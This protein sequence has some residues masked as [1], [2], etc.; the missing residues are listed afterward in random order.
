MGKRM[1]IFIV[2]ASEAFL[3]ISAGRDWALLGSLWLVG[4]H[5]RF[6]ILEWSTAVWMR[7]AG[8]FLAIVVEAIAIGSWTVQGVSRMARRDRESAGI[9][10]L[11]IRLVRSGMEVG[12]CSATSESGRSWPMRV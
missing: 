10:A 1:A 2:L 3:V 6:Q 12:R 5:M 8:P 11:R 7:A 9:Q 4:N